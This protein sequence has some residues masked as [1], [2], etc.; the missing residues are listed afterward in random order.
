MARLL[1][2]DPIT[3]LKRLFRYRDADDSFT[4]ETIID[5]EPILDANTAQR[6]SFDERSS[7]GDINKVASIP[8][9]IYMELDR[10]G[11]TR[12]E[13]AFRRWLDDPD[14]RAFRTRPGKLSR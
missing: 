1:D 3:G 2:Y 4:I 13:K 10:K 11:I 9:N 5:A 7:W 6:N 12:D 14:N 8:M